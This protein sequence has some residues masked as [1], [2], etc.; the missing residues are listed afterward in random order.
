MFKNLALALFGVL[1]SAAEF[2]V[3]LES[4]VKALPKESFL[5]MHLHGN[6]LGSTVTPVSW[7]E[8]ES[9]HLYDVAEGT[10]TPVPAIVGDW[11]TLHLDVIFNNDVNVVG[12]NVHLDFTA[13]GSTSPITLYA[14]DFAATN[15]GSYGAG[16]EYVD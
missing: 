4:F 3:P 9:L 6:R 15:P 11:I 5:K 7:S 2:K 1:A 13:E 16:D 8:C 12:N 14:Q 10:A